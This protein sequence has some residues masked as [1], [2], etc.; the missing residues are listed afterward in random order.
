MCRYFDSFTG[1]LKSKQI[2]LN[3][4]FHVSVL[5]EQS[6]PDR[7]MWVPQVGYNLAPLQTD[8]L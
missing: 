4:S 5:R 8:I 2:Y 1:T 6:G 7:D 3:T